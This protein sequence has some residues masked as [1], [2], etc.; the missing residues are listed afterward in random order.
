[1]EVRPTGADPAV[2]P[3]FREAAAQEIRAKMDSHTHNLP[4]ASALLAAALIVV[5]VACGDGPTEQVPPEAGPTILSVTSGLLTPGSEAVLDGAN[6]AGTTAG[7]TVRVWG[8]TVTVLEASSTSLRIRLP[9]FLCGPEGDAPI[10]VTANGVA[11]DPFHHPFEPVGVRELAVGEFLRISHPEDRCLILGARGTRADYLVG[12]QS[13]TEMVGTI[14]GVHHQGM[15]GGAQAGA[16]AL[17]PGGDGTFSQAVDERRLGKSDAGGI[18]PATDPTARR[19]R[20]HRRAEADIRHRDRQALAAALDGARGPGPE[21]AT[22]RAPTVPRD[23]EPGD[24]VSLNVPD[25]SSN[26]FC[27][28]ARPVEALVRRVGTNSIW[29]EDVENP[30][31]G[32]TSDDYDLISDEFDNEIYEEIVSYFGQPTDL[33]DNGR[34]VILVTQQVNRMTESSIGFVVSVDFFPGVCPAGNGGEYYYAR[35][36]DPTG[37]IPGPDGATGNTFTRD[38]AVSLAP[39]VLAHEVTHIIQ[40][41]RRIE[42]A[43]SIP[44]IWILEGQATLA[45]EVVGHRYTGNPPRS[46]LGAHPILNDHPPTG[47]AW[48]L[49]GFFGLVSYFGLGFDQDQPFRVTSAPQECTWFSV[50]EPEPCNTGLVAYGTTWSFLRWMSDHFGGEFPGG[51][52][53]LQRRIVD[54][55]RTGLAIFEELLGLNR[56]EL[57]APW[58]A[59]LYADGRVL[60]SPDPLITF[61]SWD[62]L[63]IEGALIDQAHLV[64]VQRGFTDFQATPQVAAGSS[65]YQLLQGLGGHPPFA[66]SARTGAGGPLPEHIQLWVVRLR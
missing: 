46:N 3:S 47:V 28:Q 49:T 1:M 50:Q 29:L 38:E 22:S 5:L 31:G 4:L 44:D 32:F 59:S 24:T 55:P 60:S 34:V 57:L 18:E 20:L 10:T 42:V 61:P 37:S 41:G 56:P 2:A 62:L 25:V 11:G 14:T 53:E 9:E 23:V 54:S 35:A 16:A 66:L 27:D 15:R 19:L 33:D 39:L 30:Q 36:P 43:L 8:T 51:E 48:Y 7:N 12:S 64:P 21:T 65:Y 40:F 13:T 26:N 45:E 52:R 6:F 17:L 63:A 58:A